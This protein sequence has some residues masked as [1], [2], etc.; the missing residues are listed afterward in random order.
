MADPYKFL[1][2][3]GQAHLIKSIAILVN[4]DEE[5]LRF[6]FSKKDTVLRAPARCLLEE[7]TRFSHADQLLVRVALDFWNRRGYARL[8]DMLS[9]WDQEHWVR[10]IHSLTIL[11]EVRDDVIDQLSPPRKRKIHDRI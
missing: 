7:A 1:S 9:A 11:V 4:D 3:L 6:L 10:Y 2:G 8:G 5:L